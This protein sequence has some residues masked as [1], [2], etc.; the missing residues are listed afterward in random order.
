M[1]FQQA[2]DYLDAHASYEK[3]GRIESPT[4]CLVQRQGLPLTPAAEALAE[5]VRIEAQHRNR[6]LRPE[7][8]AP[9]A[10]ARRPGKA[11]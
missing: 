8:G 7:K 3:T 11:T 5:A 10:R 9:G 4:I 2:L 1:T 6:L